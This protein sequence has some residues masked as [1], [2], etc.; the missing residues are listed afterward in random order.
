MYV[1]AVSSTY[2]GS[3]VT[4]RAASDLVASGSVVTVPSGYYSAQATK[5]IAAATHPAPS[6]SVSA[7]GLITASHT[8]AAGYV[9]AGTST[10]I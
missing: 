7:A 4:R 6:I 8:Q 3:G 5:A 10:A 2:V 9:I 1:G